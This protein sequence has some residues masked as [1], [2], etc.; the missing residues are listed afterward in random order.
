MPE[1]TSFA[2][3]LHSLSA[4]IWVGGMFFAYVVLRPSLG[5]MDPPQRLTLW[6]NVFQRF[7]PW[8]WGIIIVL[9]ATGYAQVLM[10]FG[11][12]KSAGL[13]INIMHITGWVMIALFLYLYVAPY[14]RFREFV[15]AS[16]WSAA[17]GQLNIIRRIV[18]TNTVLG[19]LTVAIGASGR[20]WG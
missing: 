15:A 20:F 2:I 7:F 14:R 13:H 8:V 11:G 4:V 12:F 10:D 17:A 19:V 9:P 18:G 16:E 5:F 1:I 6:A 3:L